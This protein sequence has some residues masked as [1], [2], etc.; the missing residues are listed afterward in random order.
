MAAPRLLPSDATLARWRTEGLTLKQIAERIE[1]EQGIVVSIGS[2]A[3]ALSRAGLTSRVRYPEH[4]PWTPIKVAHNKAYP[5]S[6]LRLLAK[7]DYGERLTAD[8]E[9]RLQAWTERLRQEDAVV[10]YKYDSEHGFY[11]VRR[12]PEDGDGF[13]RQPAARRDAGQDQ[14][15]GPATVNS[16][17]LETF[18]IDLVFVDDLE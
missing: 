10:L 17:G 2:V 4:I 1:R 6:M 8:Q 16:E 7:R 5:L 18:S 9:K 11:Y 3:S 15:A 13:I 12:R 14:P